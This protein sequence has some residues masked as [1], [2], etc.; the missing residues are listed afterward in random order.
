MKQL[1]TLL[2]VLGT[3]MSSAQRRKSSSNHTAKS[4]L[5]E[6]SVDGLRFRHVGTAL[7]S[8]RIADFAVNPDD[9]TEYYVAVA[10]GGV[11]KTVNNGNTYEPVFDDQGSYS[12]GVV[13]MDPNNHN[14]VWVGTGE[15]NNQRSVAYGDGVYKSMDGGKSWQHMGLKNS[16][17][18]G[19]I[20][21]DPTNSDIV[22]V[23]AVGPLWGKGGDR[24]LYKTTDGGKS[25]NRVLHLNEHTGVNEVHMD[26]RDPNVLYA[27]SHQRRRHVF[28]YIS[29]GP[30]SGVHKSTD[31]GATWKKITGGLPSVDLGRIGLAISPA[32][33]EYIYAIVEAARGEGG[34]YISTTRGESW[35]KRSSYTSSGN[36]YQEIIADPVDPDKVYSMNTWMKVTSDG[37]RTFNNVG[38]DNKHV[39][40]H[41]LWINPNNTRH[42]LA[43][44]D[45][46]VYETW[47]TG[48]HWSYKANL[49][50][51][52]FYKVSVDNTKPFYHIYGGTQ[53]NNSLGGPSRT[54]SASSIVNEDWYITQGGDGFETQVDPTNPDISYV[55]AQYGVLSRHDR[56]SGELKGI[57]P[58]ERKGE[59][60][61]RWNWDAPL[62]V[63]NH[64]P[65]RL[66]FAANKLFRSDDR[67]D[68]WE[69]LGDDLT[70]QI[71]RNKLKV[72]D[73]IW[74][75][76][77]V[78]K[79]GS[80]SPYGTIVAFSESPVNE[81]LLVVGTDDGLI[82]ISKDGGK[83]WLKKSTFPGIPA[84]TYVNM[85]YTSKH[86]EQ[87]I[88]AVFNNHKRGDFKPYIL[89]STDQGISWTSLSSNLPARGSTYCLEEDRVDANLLF[90]GTE[91][92]AF[93]SDNGGK[94]WKQ[95]KAG[96]PTIAVRDMAIQA[97]EN[98]L[99]LGTFGRGFYVLDDYSS[100]RNV[101]STLTKKAELYSVR[102]G[103]LFEYAYPLGLKG[104]A[105][106]G[107]NYFMG[108]NLGSEVIFTY[109]LKEDIKSRAD[110]RKEKE[111]EN[112]KRGAD[113]YFPSYEA[114]KA[115]KEEEKPSLL[116]AVKDAEGKIVR[117]LTA[118]PSAGISR[119]KWDLRNTP[120]NPVN[121][122]KPAFYNPWAEVNEGT[123]VAPGIYSVTMS[124]FVD[125]SET[126]LGTQSFN[127]I[128]LNNA[129][130]PAT[131]RKELVEFMTMAGQLRGRVKSVQQALSEIQG[132]LMQ[133]KA[134]I[135]ATSIAQSELLGEFNAIDDEV[136]GLDILVNGDPVAAKLDQ[137]QV[138]SLSSR[139]GSLAW[140]QGAS[141]AAPTQTHR[142]MFKLT[143]EELEPV[144]KATK[145]ILEVKMVAF[146]RKLRT[147][148]A[149][150]TPGNLTHLD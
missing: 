52:Q 33:P 22:Y 81:N 114:L 36:Y 93:F 11:W 130:L 84:N 111:A 71:D 59:N 43:G 74:S 25:W 126:V 3:L 23:A 120:K 138:P 2:L 40:N 127:L 109:Y 8:G 5:S 144:Y 13:T 24:G 55:Q 115:E 102:N 45:G 88:Y 73:R 132:E 50:I 129:T 112:L 20:V 150:Y 70:A 46:G 146:K 17:H 4:I 134:A 141:T 89:K 101:S 34:F 98:D 19:S 90:A 128:P 58:K 108:E 32:N 135:L 38:E 61:Y 87:I 28:T 67:G 21:V 136:K 7:M 148:G 122:N 121:L 51:T 47:N 91:F 56:Q 41:C 77:A 131:D 110:I 107:D 117:K 99:V 57:Q 119:L 64:K 85:V 62:Q 95:L 104:A 54:V 83:S 116:F 49:S 68:S 75:V 86:N 72:M 18:I 48:K 12:I 9:P 37:G 76:D 137:G 6:T 80:T 31:G 96:L 14:V 27:A 140:E 118:E 149:P 16:E 79:N 53:D 103:L 26:P 100:L 29:G 106:Q 105:T 44:C 92:G 123:M 147:A 1:L 10:S 78:S 97:D 15:N 143:A 65:Q 60:E 124:S 145:E 69:V 113:N 94:E 66:Y 42:M 82:Q 133:M 63:S 142:D 30:G 139:S 35:E 125:G 39:D